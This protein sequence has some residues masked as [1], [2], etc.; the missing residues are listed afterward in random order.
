MTSRSTHEAIIR[1]N[2]IM[3][4]S[5]LIAKNINIFEECNEDE[6]YQA[7]YVITETLPSEKHALLSGDSF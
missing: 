2:M 4:Y 7:S 3:E 1:K 6:K 5:D